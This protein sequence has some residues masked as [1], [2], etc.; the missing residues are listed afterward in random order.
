MTLLSVSR[1]SKSFGGVRAL[2]DVSFE[3]EAG[4]M[5]AMIGPNGAG[6][7]TCFNILTGQLEPDAG[8]V[9]LAG[10]RITGMRSRAI[11]RLG[12]GRTFQTAAV[13]GSL[14]L[15]ENVQVARL[16]LTNAWQNG[17]ASVFALDTTEALALLKSVGLDDRITRPASSLAYG[18]VKR[19]ELAIALAAKPRLLL[20]DEPTAGMAADER[21]ALMQLVRRIVREH[22]T[23]AL[24][25]EHSMD[26]VFG[27]ADEVMVLDRG[28]LIARGTGDAIRNDPAVQ[29]AYLGYSH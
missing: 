25:T 18:G 17:V 13:F 27:F 28:K 21:R 2:V 23:A 7:S 10:G 15:L 24:F 1:L 14:T 26:A 8:E 5:L 4:R 22:N 16:A 9:T 20:M 3:L 12:V 11:A 19:L 29:A 6:K